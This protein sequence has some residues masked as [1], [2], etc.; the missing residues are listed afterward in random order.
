[1]LTLSQA[2][3]YLFMALGVELPAFIVQ[4]AIDKALPCVPAMVDAGYSNADQV[5]VLCI[6]V[7]IIAAA[8]MP[9][10]LASQGAPTGASRSFKY[11]DRD[12]W[13]LRRSLAALDTAGVM[14]QVVGPDPTAVTLFMVV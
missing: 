13:A 4:A 7:A 5:M 11:T 8:G 1:M 12:L 3:Q 9:K 2:Q 14:T 10:R 6:A